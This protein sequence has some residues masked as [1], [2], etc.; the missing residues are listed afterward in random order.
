MRARPGRFPARPWRERPGSVRGGAPAQGPMPWA[1]AGGPWH[2]AGARE[3]GGG[4]L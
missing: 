4:G 3:S 1:A 2:E